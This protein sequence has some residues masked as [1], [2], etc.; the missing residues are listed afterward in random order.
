MDALPWRN[1][2]TSP[3]SKQD[4]EAI[5][6][7]DAKT[8]R[9][10][11]DG[12]KRYATPLLRVKNMPQLKAPK[13]AVISQL[14]A[15]EKRLVKNPEQAAA[16]SAEIH[17]LEQAGY[18]VKLDQHAEQDSAYS[19]YIPHHI[20]HHN[21]KNRVVFNCSFSYQGQNL[22]ELLLP[23]PVLG[24]SLLAVLLR[25][26]EHS[27]AVSS[28][29]RG[30]FHQV[31]LLQE[32][33]PLL[34]FLWRDFKVQEQPNVFE[35]QVLPFGTTCSAC[36]AVYALQIHVLDHSRPEEDVR[37]SV[38]KS[39]Y[40]CLQ[41]FTTTEEAKSFV[42]KLRTLL[43]DGGFELRQ[44][45]SN[46]PSTIKHLSSEL[47][48]AELWISHGKTDTQE[49]ALGL[50]WNHQTD[51]ISYRYR[52]TESTEI[53]MCNIYK[54]LA[55]QYD[56]LGYLIPYTTRAKLIVQRLWDKKRDWD[57]PNLPPDQLQTWTEWEVELP[58]LPHIAFPRSYTGPAKDKETSQ[59]DIH[60]F[61]DASER[62]YGSVAYLRIEDQQGDVEVSF[63]TARSKVAPK[64]QQS[65]PRLELC[66]VLTGAQLAKVV[67][68]ELTLPIHHIMLWTDSTTVLF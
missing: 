46:Q 53:T 23:G 43:A 8:V 67:S 44:W 24:P 40:N 18:A 39:F 49:S 12:V 30:M 2:K 37:H 42:D 59:R 34:R 22:N 33:R 17:K 9:V 19:W 29:I 1:E 41:S 57:D 54:T 45:S 5:E 21:G 65:I 50:L 16:Y 68:S 11:V 63:L 10:E 48:S 7:L 52:P 15:T 28:D 61:C 31:R 51:T 27:I 35:W 25:F 55:S 66:A 4:R 58:S 26:R 36:C 14:R 3:R 32:D 20:V 62:A 60:I 13:E 56:P 47:K 6:L 38:L 64:K